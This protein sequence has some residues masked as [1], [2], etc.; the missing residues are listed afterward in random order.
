MITPGYLKPGDKIGIV[1][2]SRKVSRDEM[3]HGIA[4]LHKEGFE[5]VEGKNLYGDHYQFSGNDNERAA[6][7]Q[8]MI[9]DPDIKAIICA[10]G[11]YGSVRIIDELHFE[12]LMENPKW[13]VGYSDATVLHS[14]IHHSTGVET[15][16][17]CMMHS[18]I[19]E[20]YDDVSFRS[21]IS[22]LKGEPVA[23]EIPVAEN[24]KTLN[25]QGENTSVVVGGNL[26]LLYSLAGS[27][28]DIETVGKILFLEDLDEY[29]YHID[30]MMMNLK[31]TRKIDF[32][33][34][35]II[36]GMTDMK[37]NTIPYGQSAYEIIFEHVREFEY[38]VCF[39]FPA[40]HGKENRALIFGREARLTVTEQTVSLEFSEGDV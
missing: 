29:L 4:L 10:R 15:L 23:Y 35:L 20:K 12:S 36:G 28:S 37:D 2:P 39:G 34:G 21:M 13:I 6:D 32:L 31:R 38:P 9:D 26:S 3:A 7:L 24:F 22:A 8:Q 40:G 14:H 11:G 25:R 18:L 33:A 17:A 19:P 30:R 27:S 16:H 1:A 5:I